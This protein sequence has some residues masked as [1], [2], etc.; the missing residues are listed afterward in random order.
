[1]TF[2]LRFLPKGED[3]ADYAANARNYWSTPP[4]IYHSTQAV[5]IEI[6]K[7][8]HRGVILAR[9]LVNTIRNTPTASILGVRLTEDT[10]HT[11][12]T[13][14]C[15]TATPTT[16]P[17]EFRRWNSHRLEGGSAS[18]N[19]EDEG[20]EAELSGGPDGGENTE[21]SDQAGHAPSEAD[22]AQEHSL[23]AEASDA[24]GGGE[25]NDSQAN[26]DS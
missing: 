8:D 20:H 13:H 19:T 12:M 2:A 14:T 22:D 21:S 1:M 11:L 17:E 23:S 10:Y 7:G 15:L 24:E 25:E 16:L 3:I 18:G 6:W 5:W 26:P 4:S 9:V